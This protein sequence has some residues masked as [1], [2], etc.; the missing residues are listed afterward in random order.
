VVDGGWL[1][2]R[3]GAPRRRGTRG[4][5][6]GDGGGPEQPIHG[7]T[8]WSMKKTVGGAADGAASASGGLRCRDRGEPGLAPRGGAML[9][10]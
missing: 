8:R 6:G 4:S 1:S 9:G 3:G 2:G 10:G 5:S 7:G